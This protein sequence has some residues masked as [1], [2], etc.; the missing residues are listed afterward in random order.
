ME[1]PQE[2]GLEFER[3]VADG[4]LA[5]AAEAIVATDRDGTIRIWN[6]G[7]QRIFGYSAEEAVGQSLDLIIPER[8]RA[9]H[10]EGYRRVMKTGTSR[11]GEGD[12]LA[13]PGLRKDGL[14]ISVEFTIVP[15]KN[16]AGCITGMAAV[17]RDVT[18]RFN[19]MKALRQKLAEAT[20]SVQGVADGR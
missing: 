12:L 6:P 16:E 11:Y 18:A 20:G 2:T 19:E 15:L 17:M 1:H 10:W 7:A 14:R 9:S 8:L 3:S 13:V 5:A 4:I